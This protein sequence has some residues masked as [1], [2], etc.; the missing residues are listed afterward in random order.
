VAVEWLAVHKATTYQIAAMLA[1][2]EGR[3]HAHDKGKRKVS[4]N[5]EV[6]KSCKFKADALVLRASLE[7]ETKKKQRNKRI[8]Q[9]EREKQKLEEAEKKL[10]EVKKQ[11]REEQELCKKEKEVQ[12]EQEHHEVQCSHI[13]ETIPIQVIDSSD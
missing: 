13:D 7:I 4:D 2:T 6:E 12:Q 3:R 11:L 8:A 1:T 10:Q 5:V 9:R